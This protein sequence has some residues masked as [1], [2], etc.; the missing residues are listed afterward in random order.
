MRDAAAFRLDWR[1]EFKRLSPYLDGI[2]GGVVRVD[3]DS[4]DAAPDKFNFLLKEYFGKPKN[5]MRCSLRIDHEWFTTR[6]VFGILDEISR[7]LADAGFPDE[8][9]PADCASSGNIIANNSVDGNMTVAISNSTITINGRVDERALRARLKS[10]CAAMRRYV[11]AG[12]HFMFV[13]NDAPLEDQAEFWQRIWN[14]GLSA[15]V[16]ENAVLV[17]GA[18]PKSGKRHHPDSPE[19]D[20]LIVLPVSVETDEAR[21]DVIY[22]DLVEV[23]QRNGVQGAEAAAQTYLSCHARSMLQLNMQLSATLLSIRNREARRIG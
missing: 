17:V 13:V 15:A 19:P 5:G 1:S 8:L 7:I 18:G 21:Q 16:G 22:D 9:D 4:E 12:G 23:F 2:R 14:A 6:Q 3:Y 11:G 10:T 20:E